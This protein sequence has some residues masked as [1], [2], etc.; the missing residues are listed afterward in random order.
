MIATLAELDRATG[1]LIGLA[2]F[3]AISGLCAAVCYMF[4]RGARRIG[5][6]LGIVAVA[7]V[8]SSP[9]IRYLRGPTSD[10]L[11]YLPVL[12]GFL[13]GAIAVGILIQAG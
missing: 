5:W 8:F 12:A 6:T 1:K 7:L 10:Y 2:G 13:V 9:L 3:L 11:E 4:P